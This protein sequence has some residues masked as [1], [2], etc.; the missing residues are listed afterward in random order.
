ML[1]EKMQAAQVFNQTFSWSDAIDAAADVYSGVS[2]DSRN[3]W[4]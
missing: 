1:R 4:V 2:N 3:S